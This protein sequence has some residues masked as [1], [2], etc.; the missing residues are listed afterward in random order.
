MPAAPAS[1]LPLPRFA[2]LLRE[3]RGARRLSQLELSAASGVS[4]R[5]LSFL[6]TGRARP[7]RE[8]VLRLA[9]ALGLPHRAADEL[10]TA[11]GFPPLTPAAPPAEAAALVERALR[12]Y[13]DLH[14]PFPAVAADRCWEVRAANRAFERLV[15]ALGNARWNPGRPGGINLLRAALHPAGI[16]PFIA[17][18]DEIAAETWRR[19]AADA[20][21]PGGSDLRAVL[22]E[23]EAHVPA[24]LR[25]P[26]R[27][28]PLLPILPVRLAT[29]VGVLSLISVVATFG[30]AQDALA[31]DLRIEAFIPADAATEAFF[32]AA[33]G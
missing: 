11:A 22:A 20:L 33:A 14:E 17:N 30:T 29:P 25:Q 19:A 24:V 27:A 32:R 2:A 28:R 16:R 7:G 3:Y 1:E 23:L 6:E 5:H 26:A 10:L 15:Q 4:Q 21:E 31:E 18:W 13:L 9:A 8:V 12:L